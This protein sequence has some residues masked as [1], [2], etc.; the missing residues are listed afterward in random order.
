M[1]KITL[2]GTILLFF[3]VACSNSTGDK[4]IGEWE[5]NN[6]CPTTLGEGISFSKD[7]VMSV[8]DGEAYNEWELDEDKSIITLSNPQYGSKEYNFEELEN[9]NIKITDGKSWQDSCEM[10]K[11]D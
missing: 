9:N 10:K 3:M 5:T 7:G 1:K 8:S 4:L 2:L 11:I 6:D